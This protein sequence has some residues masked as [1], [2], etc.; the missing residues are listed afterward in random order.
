MEQTICDR[1]LKRLEP[2]EKRLLRTKEIRTEVYLRRRELLTPEICYDLC[3]E[4][5]TLFLDFM[6]GKAIP[7]LNAGQKG[8]IRNV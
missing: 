8:D 3:P 1:C 7:P 2:G 6:E 5:K 4:C